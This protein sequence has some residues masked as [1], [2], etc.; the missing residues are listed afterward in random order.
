[1]LV[2]AMSMIPQC[3]AGFSFEQIRYWVGDGPDT[4]MLVVD[5]QDGTF[6]STYAWGYLFNGTATGE[7]LLNAVADADPNFSIVTGGG[8]LND[9]HFNDHAGIGGNPDYWGTWTHSD[10]GWYMN[11]G[12][13]EALA[14]GDR[15]GCSYTDFA[16]ALAPGVAL[17]ALDPFA[18]DQSG[19]R[20][21]TGSGS[22]SAILVVD[23]HDGANFHSYAWGYLFDGIKTG[24]DMLNAVADADPNFSVDMGGFLNDIIYNEH[25]GIG[26]NPDYWGTWSGTSL[27]NWSMNV[28]IQEPLANGDWFGCSYTDFNPALRP[29]KP[30][31]AYDPHAFTLG[32][33]TFWSGTGS[34]SAVLVVDFLDQTAVASFAWG[35]LF[36]GSTTGEDMLNAVAGTDPGFQVNMAGGFL[37]DISYNGKDGTGGSPNWWSTWSGTNLGNWSMNTGITETVHPGDW[38]GCTYTDFSPAERPGIPMAAMAPATGLK[39]DRLDGERLNIFPN[40]ATSDIQVVLPN[41][42]RGEENVELR[43]YDALGREVEKQAVNAATVHADISHL[44]AGQYWIRIR[45]GARSIAQPFIRR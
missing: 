11:T 9:I 29:Y 15:F 34:D 30:V 17:P 24:E 2:A 12:I 23:F 37:N 10:T 39:E 20:F 28:G 26:G 6:D 45:S 32:D 22:D 35:I 19:V 27:G 13:T 44:A 41:D 38:F 16:P 33:V 14:N 8:F 42:L 36:D 43:V 4:A 5:F 7:D 1:M 18:F 40:P 3:F 31:A 25:A 21:W